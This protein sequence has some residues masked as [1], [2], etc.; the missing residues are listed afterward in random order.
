MVYLKN[1]G[2]LIDTLHAYM[3][4]IVFP[5][6]YEGDVLLDYLKYSNLLHRV[7]CLAAIKTG[8]VENTGQIIHKERP[9]LPLEDLVHFRE[10]AII[11][12]AANKDYH[13]TVSKGLNLCQFKN[14][15]FIDSTLQ[16]NLP[17][18]L[19]NICYSDGA[20][21]QWFVNHFEERLN[22]IENRILNQ[23][24]ISYLNH[25]AFAEY[26][27]C[28]RDKEIVIVAGGPT[29]N[30]YKPI[31]N[32]IHIGMN[33]AWR[34]EDI[35]FDYLFT[36]DNDVNKI[37]NSIK[38]SDGFDKIRDKI[39]IGKYMENGSGALNYPEEITYQKSNI[40]RYSMTEGV[41]DPSQIIYSD[42]CNYGL[43]DFGSISFPALHFAL[44]TYPK[45]IYLVG[46]DTYSSKHFY[47]DR[48]IVSPKEHLADYH[49][50][51][52]LNKPK[53]PYRH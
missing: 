41:C 49:D 21:T 28:F 8:R 1:L 45:K 15:A 40:V 53:Y 29:V 27:N 26:R 7:C 6:G 25:K 35:N 38:I 13:E 10:S 11:I 20:I 24:E 33:F 39:F 52:K 43:M 46:C 37:P 14:V 32:A 9:V 31:P 48:N 51:Y 44:F 12:V 23:N 47:T 19:R 36:Q 34:R 30:Y 18:E 50:K 42:I 17:Q 4:V 3:E 2:E 5:L 16:R 22:K